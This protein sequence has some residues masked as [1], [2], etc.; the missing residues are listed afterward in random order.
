[1]TSIRKFFGG[2]TFVAL[3]G[4]ESLWAQPY[5]NL[6][7]FQPGMNFMVQ[8][9]KT[10]KTKGETQP[11]QGI[12]WNYRDLLPQGD[13][14]E[15]EFLLPTAWDEQK[16]PGVKLIEKRSDGAKIYVRQQEGRLYLVGYED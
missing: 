4:A 12:T 11:G 6:E 10:K 13:K 1:M 15:V 3:W 8:P 9:C 7:N 5:E 2:L 14:V 16:Y